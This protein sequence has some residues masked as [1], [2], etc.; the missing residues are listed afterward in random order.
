MDMG[1]RLRTFKG[2]TGMTGGMAGTGRRFRKRLCWPMA[3]PFALLKK[4][5]G[6]R[7]MAWARIPL[8]ASVRPVLVALDDHHCVVK[9]PLGWWTRNHLGS[10]Y[11]GA[12]AIGADCAGGYLAVDRIRRLKAPVSLV[13]KAFRAEFLKRPESDV[14]FICEEGTHI[15]ALVDQVL[16][17]GER[18]T[19]PV[20]VRAATRLAGGEYET[21]AEFTLELSLK[22]AGSGVL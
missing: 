19:E 16:A 12:L 11:F 9:L 8:L 14:Y 6:L 4:T 17:S 5:L 21:V 15:E 13:F 3:T 7:L 1:K 2:A 22:K 10:M 20:Q 18:Q